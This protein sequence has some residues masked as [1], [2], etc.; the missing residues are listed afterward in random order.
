MGVVNIV[1]NGHKVQDIAMNKYILCNETTLKIAE[2]WINFLRYGLFYLR[3][4]INKLN[5][6]T[7]LFIFNPILRS[8][9][10]MRRSANILILI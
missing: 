8:A 6:F 3:K 2:L 4:T 1:L 10:N 9:A 7:A 5:L